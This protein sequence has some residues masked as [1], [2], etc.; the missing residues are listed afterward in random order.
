VD[1]YI[2]V[3][4]KM[5]LIMWKDFTC[6]SSTKF[7]VNDIVVVGKFYQK[8]GWGANSYVLLKTSH[9]AYV[10]VSHVITIQFPMLLVEHRVQGNDPVYLLPH[11]A[12]NGIN[13]AIVAMD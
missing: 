4:T 11:H 9:I 6:H 8:W 12:L 1:F 7:R 13:H 10:H 3:C 2:L 5:V